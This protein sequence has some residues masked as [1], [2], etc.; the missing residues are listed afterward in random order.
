MTTSSVPTQNASASSQPPRAATRLAFVD[1]LRGIACVW[2][3]QVHVTNACMAWGYRQSWMFN[4]LNTTNG[5]VSVTFIFCAGAG[6]WL[7][8]SRRADEYKRFEPSLWQY[9][10]RLGFILL[11]AYWLHIPE[12]SF[13]KFLISAPERQN[14]LF[15]CDVLHAIVMASLLALG[16]LLIVPSRFGSQ[17][18]QST[19][20]PQTTTESPLRSPLLWAFIAMAVVFIFGAPFVWQLEPDTFLPRVIGSYLSRPPAAAFPLFPW[21]GYFFVGASLMA[22]FLALGDAARRRMAWWL[23]GVSLV[24]PALTYWLQE[25][26]SFGWWLNYGWGKNWY[27][28]S[29]GNCLFR[30]SGSV[31]LFAVLYLVEPKLTARHEHE[32][33]VGSRIA[34]WLQLL[35]QESL[36][37]YV[38]HLMI[39]YGSPVNLGLGYFTG[40]S[41]KPIAVLIVT[42]AIVIAVW[43]ATELWQGF[44]RN[45]PEKQ[46]R[47]IFVFAC[48]FATIFFVTTPAFVEWSEQQVK[49]YLPRAAAAETPQDASK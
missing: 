33:S 49:K 38:F 42:V 9:L 45:A 40:Q 44:K 31:L 18:S 19:A 29:P 22:F 43:V 20:S 16:L 8:A 23:V 37:V 24:L 6:F 2:M 27:L 12:L 28:S 34:G 25:F 32:N 5:Y 4:L 35:G 10:R 46:R 3:I 47:F 39:V 26:S 30:V 21:C 11:V 14:I 7:A 48:L 15:M 17:Q 1:I 41:F 36:F 13:Q